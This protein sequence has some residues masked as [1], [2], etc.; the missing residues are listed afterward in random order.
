MAGKVI[1]AVAGAGKTFYICN[2]VDP[3][4][5]NLLLAFTRENVKN[6]NRE[7]IRRFG[8]VPE[9]TFVMTYHSFLHQFLIRPYEQ[10]IF[11]AFSAI[12]RETNG[13]TLKSPPESSISTKSGGYIKN[14]QY[15]KV[16]SIHHYMNSN[17][18]YYCTLMASLLM[19]LPA[20]C[21]K[22][23]LQNFSRFFDDI[24]IDEF[25][26]F[27]QKEYELLLNI[28]KV[29]ERVTMV[30]DYYQ[31]S[32]SGQNNSGKPYGTRTNIID[33]EAFIKE[34]QKQNIEVDNTTLSYSY[35]CSENVC[36]YI[37]ERLGI[38][39]KGNK[40]RKG[41]IIVLDDSSKDIWDIIEDDSIC[42]LVYNNAS[43]KL[44]KCT[45][46][47]YSKGNTYKDICVV[48]TKDTV[49]VLS[50][51]IEKISQITKNK[52]YVAL[53]RSSGN[54]YLISPKYLKER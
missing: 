14:P 12:Y 35:R 15:F 7:L 16:G 23:I 19:Y 32:V 46:W 29:C 44:F 51:K 30:G 18:E 10:T 41:D 53:T 4:R 8:Y 33:Y 39:I 34:L 26:D 40:E 9:K 17:C 37:R 31:H 13:V 45:N 27:R 2:A 6:L 47:S 52:L 20:R 50:G 42:K 28:C 5:K 48:L 22:Q 1:L 43:K 38:Y 21:L 25:Q 54:V 24:Y 36:K 11:K 3:A 49:P